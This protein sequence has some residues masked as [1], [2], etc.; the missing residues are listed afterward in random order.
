MKKKKRRS[1]ANY[2]RSVLFL[3]LHSPILSLLKDNTLYFW[4]VC[5]CGRSVFRHQP[6][7]NFSKKKRKI[8]K[9]KQNKAQC[10]T[11]KL[12]KINK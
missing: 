6:F 8:R 1:E 4:S 10:V 9:E 7:F 12:Q 2:L 5:S 11:R 3:L